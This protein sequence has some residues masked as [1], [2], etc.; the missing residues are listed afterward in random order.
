[1][2]RREGAMNGNEEEMRGKSRIKRRGRNRRKH[3]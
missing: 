3:N 1:M 2:C